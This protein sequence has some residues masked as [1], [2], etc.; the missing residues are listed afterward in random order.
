MSNIVWPD[1]NK[2]FSSSRAEQL[3]RVNKTLEFDTREM[4][5]IIYLTLG[6]IQKLHKQLGVGEWSVICLRL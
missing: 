4:K 2:G 1:K 5:G 6:G 3:S